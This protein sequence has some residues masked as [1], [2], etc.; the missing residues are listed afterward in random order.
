LLSNLAPELVEE[1]FI[2]PLEESSEVT[3]IIDAS[4]SCAIL[5]GAQHTFGIVE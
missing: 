2:S 1:L 4:E 5:G 3:R